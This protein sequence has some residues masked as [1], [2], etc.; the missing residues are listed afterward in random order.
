MGGRSRQACRE[1]SAVPP[2]PSDPCPFTDRPCC[3]W[4]QVIDPALNKSPWTKAEDRL[5]L[6]AYASHPKQWST[7]ALRLLPVAKGQKRRCDKDIQR[8]HKTLSKPP[9]ARKPWTAEETKQLAQA[10]EQ[11]GGTRDWTAIAA[12][13]MMPGGRSAVQCASKWAQL[14]TAT[15]TSSVWTDEQDALLKQAMEW[16]SSNWAAIA[17]TVPGK[18]AKECKIR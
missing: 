18:T 11:Q 8:R 5:L 10:V 12:A 1:R 3:R 2:P 14:V 13:G 6:E 15:K 4:T 17:A 9:A 16:M 7:I